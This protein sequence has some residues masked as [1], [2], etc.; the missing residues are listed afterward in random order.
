LSSSHYTHG[1]EA[2]EQQRLTTLNRLLNDACVAEAR[3]TPRAR[4][5]DFGAGLGQLSRAMARITGVPVLGIERSSEQIR[6]AERQAQSDG[7]SHLL[8]MREGSVD[9]VPLSPE[10]WGTFDVA[11]ARFLL[12][13][14]PDPAGVV[15]SMVKAVRP[16]GRIILADDDY[17]MLRLWPEPPGFSAVWRAYQRS[18]DRHGNDPNVGRRLVQL[19]QE[20]G[21]RPSRNTWVFFGSCSGHSDFA[22]YVLNVA[23]ILDEATD[24]MAG[25]GVSG[26]MT[27]DL[28]D[29]L[30]RWLE[31]PDAALWHGISWAEGLKP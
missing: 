15:R 25:I 18:Y 7:E 17:E 20:G 29:E 31:R 1:S 4:I 16:G 26:G 12:E 13:H 14:V 3:L 23:K 30:K 11:H 22:A 24:D 21:A 28:I 5:I 2:A 10:E 8:E 19:L 9:D 27:R 6:E